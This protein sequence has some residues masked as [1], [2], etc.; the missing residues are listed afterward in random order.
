MRTILLV[1]LV[2]GVLEAPAVQAQ[3]T[4]GRIEGVA[5][6]AARLTVPRQ[7][8]RVYA[9]PG[10]PPST[11]PVID[12]P[13]AGVVIALESTPALQQMSR[14]GAN[15]AMAQR[16]EHFVP[17]VMSIASGTTVDFP[18][19]DALY[20]NVFSLSSAKSFDLGRYTRGESKSVRFT[21]PGVVQI[22]CHI[23]ADMN[24]FILVYDNP[25][26]ATPDELGRFTL[27][28][29]PPGEYTLIAW[30][31]RI[32]PIRVPVRVE[33]GRTATAQVAIPLSDRVGTP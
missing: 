20:H 15:A 9:E 17:H 1:V 31:E 24:G 27:E 14:T 10:T 18:N 26:F 12:H 16:G 30:H 19:E 29:V 22:F 5:T 11:A 21:R 13:F 25:F 33:A 2:G 6:I 28:G 8:V 7:R 32:R 23:H 3:A 4:T